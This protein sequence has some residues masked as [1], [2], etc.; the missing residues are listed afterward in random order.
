VAKDHPNN[1]EIPFPDILDPSRR[2]RMPK[3]KSGPV[4]L[5]HP[6]WLYGF[7]GHAKVVADVLINCNLKV[8]GVVDDDEEIIRKTKREVKPGFKLD[9]ESFIFSE[10]QPMVICIG[11]NRIRCELA[12]Q[13]PNYFA[14][15][16]HPSAIVSATAEYGV[17]TVIM[18]GAIIQAETEIGQHVIINSGASIDHENLIGDFVH[19]SPRATLCGNVTVGEGSWIGA[20]AVVIQGVKIGRWATVGAGAVVIR[21]IPDFA[22]V[23]GNPARVI[24]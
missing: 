5:R 4:E 16:F 11:N 14:S 1:S 21:D 12:C 15:A 7:G 3:M 13:L 19:V 18:Q 24:R 10:W 8:A 23:V 17:G 6:V 2:D 9:P 22:T 20:G